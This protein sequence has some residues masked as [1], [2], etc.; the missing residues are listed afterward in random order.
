MSLRPGP[1]NVD[2]ALDAYQMALVAEPNN[3]SALVNM[4]KVFTDQ[5]QD[6]EA[7]TAMRAAAEGSR[8]PFTLIAMADVEMLHGNLDEARQYL[9]RARWW[10]GGEP[11]VHEALSRLARLE[12]EREKA[13]KH[14]AKAS[15]LRQRGQVEAENPN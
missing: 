14:Q 8:N 5:G 9:R 4:A 15:A 7:R 12:G 2:A 10:Y 3:S 1:V 6:E 13:D 11:E